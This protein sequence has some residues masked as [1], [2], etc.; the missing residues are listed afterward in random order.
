MPLYCLSIGTVFNILDKASD[1]AVAINDQYS[2]APINTGSSDEIFHHNK[3]IL[4]TVDIESRFCPLLVHAAHRDYETWGIH[5]LDLTARG[6]NPQSV[7]LDGAKGLIKG[8][9][10]ALP[11]TAIRHDHFHFIM[12]MKDCGRFLKNRVDSATTAAMKL[13]QQS[14]NGKNE[15]KKQARIEALEIAL[16][17]L[18]A[19]SALEE[20]HSTFKTLSSWLQHDVL[21]LAGKPPA[22]RAFLYDYIVSEMTALALKHPH[23]IE[24]IVTSLNNR[25]ESLLDATHALNESFIILAEKHSVSVDTIWEI[26][27]LARY[28]FDSE[29][30]V[31][32]SHH[33]EALIG[34]KYDEIEDDFL[35]ILESTHRCSSMVENFNSRLRPYLDKRKFI[36]PKRLALIQFYLNHKPFARSKHERLINKT[37]AEAMTGHP[38]KSW[39]EM[40][41]FEPFKRQVA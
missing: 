30:Y 40:L 19:L 34:R 6:Y 12:D 10:E 18:S 36:T 15:L 35:K 3:P 27:Y 22:E 21:Q 20:A 28:S 5:L 7:I 39:L 37:A 25:R 16:T 11:E 31:E 23:R 1:K 4:A 38:H 41:G 14:I 13:F 8:Y 29:Q 9:E 24:D 32:K 2:L 26:C 33:L 17:E